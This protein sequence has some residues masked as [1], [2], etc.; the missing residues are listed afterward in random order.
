MTDLKTN[1]VIAQGIIAEGVSSLAPLP[2]RKVRSVTEYRK[3]SMG[4]MLCCQS[5]RTAPRKR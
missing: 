4:A 2:G 1:D 5:L 3:T